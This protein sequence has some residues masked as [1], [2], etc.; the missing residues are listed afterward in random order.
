MAKRTLLAITQ[1]ILSATDGDEV[2]SIGD[3]MESLQ[4]VDIIR[5][6]YEEIREVHDLPSSAVLFTLEEA[7]TSTYPTQL[8]LPE[9]VS[10]M[11]TLKYAE[12]TYPEDEDTAIKKEYRD[13]LYKTPEEFM[14]IL[15]ARDPLATNAVVVSYPLDTNIK[16]TIE[17]DKFPSYWTT[18]DDEYIWFDSWDSTKTSTIVAND[19]KAWGQVQSPWVLDND[20][21]PDLPGNLFPYFESTCMTRCIAHFKQEINPEVARNNNRLRI[22]SARNKWRQGRRNNEGP[23]FGKRTR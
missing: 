12:V 19:T 10:V 22:R 7:N 11:N 2:N 14:A 21:I 16:L 23:D 9:R 20:F 18:F 13:V 5:A 3:T 17:N 1:S 15:D 4:I 6:V 8:K